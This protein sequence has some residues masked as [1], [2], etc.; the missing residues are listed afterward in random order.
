MKI[1]SSPPSSA[2]IPRSPPPRR[3]SRVQGRGGKVGLVLAPALEAAGHDLVELHDADAVV[4]FTAPETVVGNVRA[5]LRA[6]DPL[7]RRDDGL[8]TVRLS[9]LAEE[10]GVALFYAPNFAIGEADDALCDR[11]ARHLSRAEII[12]FHG[13]AK[14]DAPSGT[15]RATASAW[16]APRSTPC[17]YPASLPTR[18]SCSAATGSCL[19]SGTTLSTARPT[20]R[21]PARS[22]EAPEPAGPHGGPGGAAWLVS[23]AAS[24]AA[25]SST[26][27]RLTVTARQANELLNEYVADR[28]RGFVVFHDH[29]TGKPHGGFAVFDVRD[30]QA[31]DLLEDH[32]SLQGGMSR[33]MR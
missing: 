30:K 1:A 25:T 12:E 17:A 13:E 33:S 26:P 5:A 6:R 3:E 15:A 14:K 9:E 28:R 29:F 7:R 8:G 23:S 21:R 27:W 32:G 31:F 19:R 10:K 24:S 16:A 11:G 4:D 20:C 22:R 2:S 18:R